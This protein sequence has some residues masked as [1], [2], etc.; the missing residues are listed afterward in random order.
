MTKVMQTTFGKD[1]FHDNPG[2]CWQACLA[3]ILGESLESFPQFE[4]GTEW[5]DAYDLMNY[6]LRTLG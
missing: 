2:N 4:K 5:E 6:H 3:T 1:T